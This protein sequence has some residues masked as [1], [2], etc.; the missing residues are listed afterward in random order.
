MRPWA[1]QAGDPKAFYLQLP[2]EQAVPSIFQ[3]KDREI[4]QSTGPLN[5]PK[6]N[7]K[8]AF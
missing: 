1:W 4:G 7:P 5:E 2:S 8:K 6:L 3:Q